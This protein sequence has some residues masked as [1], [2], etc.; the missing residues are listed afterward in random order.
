MKTTGRQTLRTALAQA[1]T[2]EEFT[3]TV[4]A[5]A[6]TFGWHVHHSRPAISPDGK[7]MTRLKGNAGLPDLVMARGGRRVI[8]AE[9]K[10]EKGKTS[11]A[12][13]GWLEALGYNRP[14]ENRQAVDPDRNPEVYVWRPSNLAEI[15]EIL[16]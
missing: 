4:I 7:W 10:S 15:T 13:D 1:T 8:F 14:G 5:I 3:D 16:R 11:D 6:Q 12:Q 2:E 9:L